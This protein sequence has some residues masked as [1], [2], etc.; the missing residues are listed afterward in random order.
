MYIEGVV[1]FD[2]DMNIANKG[3]K[4]EIFDKWIFEILAKDNIGIIWNFCID[5][6]ELRI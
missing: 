6:Y 3:S 2:K 1:T 5:K 4:K